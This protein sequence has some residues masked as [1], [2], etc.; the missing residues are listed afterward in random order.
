[1]QNINAS[2]SQ[3]PEFRP[4][5][6][7]AF[8]ERALRRYPCDENFS[9]C[10]RFNRL[11]FQIK[12]PDD[13]NVVKSIQLVLPVK[14]QALKNRDGISQP[15]SMRV[16]DR[17]PAANIAVS[18]YC[19]KA[20]RTVILTLNGRSYSVDPNR[21]GEQLNRC[22]QSK[23]S[24]SYMNQHS[25]K[26][27]ALRDFAQSESTQTLRDASVAVNPDGTPVA[28]I[29]VNNP[30]VGD[31]R[32]L[33]FQSQT[34]DIRG[35]LLEHNSGFLERARKFQLGLDTAGTTWEQEIVLKLNIGPF[36][37]ETR[38]KD[39]SGV[40]Y[41]HDLSLQL[42]FD[43]QNEFERQV[44]DGS[45]EKDRR[46]ASNLFDFA[47]CVNARHFPEKLPTREGFPTRHSIEFIRRPEL[48]I[49]YNRH[50]VMLS[51]YKLRAFGHLLQRSNEFGLTV[52]SSGLDSVS[53]PVR[54]QCRLLQ[55]P[56][57][58]YIYGTLADRFKN[59]Y[60]MGGMRR[61]LL[62]E[63][64]NIRINQRPGLIQDP[65]VEVSF[66][67]F[68]R[69][70]NNGIGLPTYM[71]SPIYMFDCQSFGADWKA[72]DA[73]ISTFELTCSAKLSPLM[74]EEFS[75]LDLNA[76]LLALDYKDTGDAFL[77][78]YSD[79]SLLVWPKNGY[80]PKFTHRMELDVE[81]ARLE[82]ETFT[83]KKKLLIKKSTTNAFFSEYF[84]NRVFQ[85]S[86]VDQYG[87][88]HPEI[89]EVRKLRTHKIVLKNWIWAKW[90]N[91][92]NGHLHFY[93]VPESY[94]FSIDPEHLEA[95]KTLEAGDHVFTDY[96]DLTGTNGAIIYQGNFASW[97]RDQGA[98]PQGTPPAIPFRCRMHVPGKNKEQEIQF[99]DP[100]G[101][102]EY[103]PGPKA[104]NY[105]PTGNNAGIQNQAAL[106]PAIPDAGGNGFCYG[107]NT[108]NTYWMPMV[109]QDDNDMM[110]QT[111]QYMGNPETTYEDVRCDC[112]VN[113]G[114]EN[115]G[116]Q[117][118]YGIDAGRHFLQKEIAAD[119]T[120][121]GM[122]TYEVSCLFEN[123]NEQL[124]QRRF[125]DGSRPA[126]LRLVNSQRISSGDGVF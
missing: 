11:N 75:Q 19:W 26:P 101:I 55:V 31:L 81:K 110:L 28:G 119:S 5:R 38:G 121:T 41:I 2:N 123:D 82:T 32:L 60:A 36:S 116:Q 65:P 1:M 52:P 30:F 39:N 120:N 103:I 104:Y 22:Y 56:T 50:D 57:K 59:I 25:L 54:V 95:M 118:S 93:F 58:V 115:S 122:L 23:D 126:P 98:F 85:N 90:N 42:V 47:T 12:I 125:A 53:V 3:I 68:K 80:V 17:S 46:V 96:L 24:F 62:L 7:V 35:N 4:T 92:G 86:Q 71:K 44:Y 117:V 99:N 18:D 87:P 16:M 67:H 79:N 40:P 51:E 114:V 107:T 9:Q 10:N 63:N 21:F 124:V 106:S 89:F 91:H 6:E 78:H 111:N 105:Y 70:S 74:I 66:E 84:E 33:D 77:P 76:S 27:I 14:V 83:D 8:L 20:F 34:S 37:S 73:R 69:L 109:V 49:E 102:N 29:A 64:I 45:Y 113:R 13:Q 43:G 48:L 72:N 108:N 100:S 112:V 94:P 61:N 15:L 97:T 88:V